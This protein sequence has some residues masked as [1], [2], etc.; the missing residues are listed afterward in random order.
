VNGEVVIRPYREGDEVSINEGFNRTFGTRREL[1]EWHWKYPAEPEGRWIMLAVEAGGRVLAHY[2]AVASRFRCGEATV[3]AGQIT[4]AYALPE[5]Q[6]KKVFSECYEAF[7]QAFGRP[8]ALPL[9]YGFPTVKH[10]HMGVTVLKYVPLGPVPLLR[11]QGGRLGVGLFERVRAGF[12]AAAVEDLWGR[13]SARYR[14]GNVRDASWLGR[15]YAGRPGV[16]Y[17]HLSVWRGGRPEAWGV[18]REMGDRLVWVDL[19]W[20]GER[21]RALAVLARKVA[22]RAVRRGV[23]A[24]LWLRGDAVAEAVL[25]RCGFRRHDGEAARAV[26]RSFEPVVDL[27]AIRTG[28]YVTAGDSDL[29]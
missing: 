11:Y 4:D 9:M 27:D 8:G 28:W 15:R 5:V 18:V 6:G 29:V 12:D 25:T 2:G 17:V 26:A 1:A 19:V 16:S 10:Y 21:E 7:I 23:P 14:F 24:E 13:A 3:R 22:R 20:D